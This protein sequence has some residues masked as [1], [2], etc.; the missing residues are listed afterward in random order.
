[1]SI[2]ESRISFT[3]KVL[4]WEQDSQ[5]ETAPYTKT[6]SSSLVGNVAPKHRRSQLSDGIAISQAA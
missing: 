6:D 4:A 2:E 1:M 5:N 3:G